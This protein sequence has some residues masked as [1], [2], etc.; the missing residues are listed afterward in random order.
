MYSGVRRSFLLF[1]FVFRDGEFKRIQENAC[2]PTFAVRQT[3]ENYH[4]F[5][6]FQVFSCAFLSFSLTANMREFK[7]TP[8]FQCSPYDE[9]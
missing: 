9:L 8:V 5:L 4:V 2:F 7:K 1:T 3:Y 6:R